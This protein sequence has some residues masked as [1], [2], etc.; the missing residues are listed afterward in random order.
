LFVA[1]NKWFEHGIL[2][3]DKWQFSQELSLFFERQS[4]LN[5]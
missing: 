5:S 3:Y 2:D 1:Q 4:C